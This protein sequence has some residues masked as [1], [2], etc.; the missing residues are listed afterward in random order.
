M[1]ETMTEAM[2][3]TAQAQE[4]QEAQVAQD[5]QT[6][7]TATA[8]TGRSAKARKPTKAQAANAAKA[9]GEATDEPD[10]AL[11][12]AKAPHIAGVTDTS[13]VLRLRPDQLVID[14]AD[15]CRRFAADT[16]IDELI[17]QLTTEGHQLHP[18]TVR[19][20]DE[21]GLYR[22]VT[23]FR[24]AAALSD[25]IN[26]GAV[27]PGSSLGAINAVV[28]E[29]AW[30]DRNA[31]LTNV[32]EN[33]D[34]LQLTIIDLAQAAQKLLS[35]GMKGKDVAKKL[36]KTA[37]WL[38][39]TLPLLTLPAKV[40][41]LIHEDRIAA[42]TGYELTQ[43]TN[44][45]KRDKAI[46]KLLEEVQTRGKATRTDLRK[47]NREEAETASRASRA[48]AGE[49]TGTGR[50]DLSYKE[51]KM[52]VEEMLQRFRDED[53]GS[54]EKGWEPPTGYR[55]LDLFAKSFAGTR[56]AQKRLW[57]LLAVLKPVKS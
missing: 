8:Q 21:N 38:S 57:D 50:K 19:P 53:G 43:E 24:R 56:G 31:V 46:S 26:S 14:P 41:K 30:D 2:G 17:K 29:E 37:G 16:D 27:E 49:E 3:T 34:R 23:G 42:S 20:K 4:A 45:K 40:I 47:A 15:N 12:A 25:I 5:T 44:E 7:A 9:N 39:Q 54:G 33:T 35:Q 11:K 18:I 22:V 13:K 36:G 52:V 48:E 28:L 55:I 10:K 1:K 51:A 32:S 6:V